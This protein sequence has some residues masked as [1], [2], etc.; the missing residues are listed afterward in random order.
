MDGRALE[1]SNMERQAMNRRVMKID[2]DTGHP[3][4][5]IMKAVAL[6]VFA[7]VIAAG[8]AS[9]GEERFGVV[10]RADALAGTV[11]ITGRTYRVTA[12][13]RFFDEKGQQMDFRALRPFDIHK[14]LFEESQATKARFEADLVGG[15]WVLRR[16]DLVNE[17]PQ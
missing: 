15:A 14:G 4:A 6:M 3:R 11:I 13:S 17:L 1:R 10:E 16:L 9:A 8:P 5:R 2:P 12:K 7:I